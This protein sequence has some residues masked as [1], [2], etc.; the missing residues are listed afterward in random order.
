MSPI[1]QNLF[2]FKGESTNLV[3]EFMLSRM[4]N[5][6]Q[7]SWKKSPAE[8]AERPRVAA[9]GV[10]RVA[11]EAGVRL[12]PRP[13]SKASA[14]WS[15]RPKRNQWFKSA[16]GSAFSSLGTVSDTSDAFGEQRILL[17]TVL[18]Y[19]QSRRRLRKSFKAEILWHLLKKLWSGEDGHEQEGWVD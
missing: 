19:A 1:E 17:G 9:L 15:R 13:T 18:T 14:S 16:P 8:E 3:E 6:G 10:L 12:D 2:G 5:Q 7:A 4:P 11:Q